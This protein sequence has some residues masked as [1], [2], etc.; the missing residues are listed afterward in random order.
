MEWS[1]SASELLF[2]VGWAFI[3]EPFDAAGYDATYS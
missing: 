2:E 3:M 1:S